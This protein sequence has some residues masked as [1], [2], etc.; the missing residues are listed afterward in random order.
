M[1]ILSLR[2]GV[3]GATAKSAR[4]VRHHERPLVAVVIPAYNEAATIRDVAGAA[5]AYV[6]LVI[7]VDDGSQDGTAE[8]LSG[9][10]VVVLRNATNCGKGTSLKRGMACAVQRGATAIVTMDGDGQHMPQDAQRLLDMAQDHPDDIIIGAR[11]IDMDAFPR[12]RYYANQVANFFISWAAGYA[13]EDSQSG[14]RLYPARLL[15]QPRIAKIH[16]PG[17]AF[18]S[19]VLIEAVRLG[20]ESKPVAIAA[21]YG[22]EKRASHFRPVMDIVRITR[23]VAWKL[24]SRGLYLNGLYRALARRSARRSAVSTCAP[25]R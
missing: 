1:S 13:I 16:A 9:L 7:V 10:D 22:K 24:I 17:F 21:V 3:E 18:E 5:L 19:E 23:M 6:S 2:V 12:R 8:A 4:P 15:R 25:R 11:L 20:Y 14:F